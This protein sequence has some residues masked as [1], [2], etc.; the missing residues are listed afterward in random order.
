MLL[1]I[2]IVISLYMTLPIRTVGLTNLFLFFSDD[3]KQLKMILLKGLIPVATVFTVIATMVDADSTIPLSEPLAATSASHVTVTKL[4]EAFRKSTK[5]KQ[6]RFNTSYFPT[7]F[8]KVA[9]ISLLYYY[10]ICYSFYYS[11]LF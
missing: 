2:F 1:F 6:L 4:L 11:S 3:T 7:L 5:D 8:P 10:N 9:I